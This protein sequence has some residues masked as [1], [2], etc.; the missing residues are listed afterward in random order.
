MVGTI[1]ILKL[2]EQVV[3]IENDF[4]EIWLEDGIIYSVHKPNFINLEMAKVMVRDRLK[5]SSG[6][7]RPMFI[8]ISSM[9]STNIET[10]KYLSSEEAIYLVSAGA[11][12]T[13]NP[14]AKF[15]GNLFLRINQPKV[16]TRIFTNKQEAIEWL[17]QYK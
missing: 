12:Y 4:V 16:P 1:Q 7:V 15:A 3:T 14:I 13:A 17:Q 5:V 2:M 9:I 6:I 8:D 11:I 10:R